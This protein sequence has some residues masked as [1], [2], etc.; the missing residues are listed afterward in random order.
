MLNP[1][2]NWFQR[3][4]NWTWVLAYLFV[5]VFMLVIGAEGSEAMAVGRIGGVIVM[6]P[7]SAWVISQKGRSLWWILLA[8]LLSPLWLPSKKVK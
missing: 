5:V 8:W 3:H 2:W 4:L 6:I 7:T 1:F